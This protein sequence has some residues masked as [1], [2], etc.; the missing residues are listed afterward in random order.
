VVAL[1][2]PAGAGKS[3]VARK[4]AEALG[5]VLVDTGAIYRTVAL[6]ARRAC[7]DWGDAEA[8][9]GV[10][11]ALASDRTLSI[12]ASPSSPGG[13]KVVLAGDDV[14]AAIRTPELSRGAS[15]VSAIRGV[16][17]ALLDMQR[18]AAA[19]GGVV[20]EGRDIGTV[21]I[22]DAEAKFFVTA[23]PE[24]RA[25]RRY[26]ELTERGASVTY[27]ETLREVVERDEADAGRAIAPLKPAADAEIVDTSGMS[28]DAVVEYLVTRVRAL[29]RR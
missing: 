10:A 9:T 3:T 5:F 26:D 27:E 22:P 23:S 19:G 20:L 24:I 16:R 7:V 1:D 13:T 17:A 29:P 28:I 4:V 2:G 11:R 14:S 21:V 25:R 12:T 15:S 18:T 6:L 8:V